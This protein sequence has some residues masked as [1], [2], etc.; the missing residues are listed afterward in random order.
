MNRK[1]LLNQLKSGEEYDVL[2]IGGGATGLGVA[3][4]AI[5]RGFKVALLEKVDFGKGTSSKA[6]KLLHGGVRYLQNGDVGLVIE[7]L[8]E[9]EFVLTQASHLSH[10]QKFVIPHYSNWQGW[11]Y[12][13]GLKT[14]D[15]LSG[16]RSLGDTR[17]ISKEETLE[18]LPNLK[19]KGLKGGIEYTDGQFDDTRLCI[20]LVSTI[21]KLGG[22]VLN[23]CSLDSFIYDEFGKINGGVGKDEMTGDSFEIKSK[24]VV[25]ATGVFAEQ[26]MALESE[27]TDIKIVPARGSHIVLDRSFLQSDEAIM[28]PKTTDGRVLFLVPW[29]NVVIVGT[30]DVV[31]P[32]LTM[33]PKATEKEINF[34][35]NN[36][37]EYLEKKPTKK[38]ILSTFA[39]L[40]PL[41]AP[42]REGKKSKEI[43]RSHKVL[44][45]KAGL[46]SVLGGKWTT[47]RK[48]GEDAVDEIIEKG[49]LPPKESKSEETRIYNGTPKAKGEYIHPNLP[50]TW[51]ELQ[52]YVKEELVETVED[53]LC[54]RT[55]CI[56]LHKQATLD[57]LEQAIQLI[58]KHKG[59]DEVWEGKQRWDFAETAKSY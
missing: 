4:D 44:V 16:T 23:Y 29:H 7:A 21:N 14:Y 25:N 5:S 1:Q 22:T 10:I 2:V 43:S 37:A 18:L 55:R 59:Y 54:R 50:Y 24:S 40:R 27:D 47:F 8:R 35:L 28:I 39:G 46:V 9:R 20:D 15:L 56:L 57:V 12:W 33:E 6:T 30:T 31:S 48:M 26:T 58:A 32:E 34:I 53:L 41:A 17:K 42:K 45:S 36:A 13:A 19:K 51:V 52:Q 38:D 3:L 11:Y 49:K